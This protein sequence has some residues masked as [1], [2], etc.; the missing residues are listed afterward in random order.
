MYVHQKNHRCTPCLIIAYDQGGNTYNPVAISLR[1]PRRHLVCLSSCSAHDSYFII[2]GRTADGSVGLF[3]QSFTTTKPPRATSP[4]PVHLSE[5]ET[6]SPTVQVQTPQEDVPWDLLDGLAASL[7]NPSKG[8]LIII[9]LVFHS[10][11]NAD[12]GDVQF[13]CL[14][15]N[16]PSVTG[17]PSLDQGPESSPSTPSSK[18][19]PAFFSSRAFLRKRVIYAHFDILT[20]RSEYFATMLSSSFSENA[21]STR[22]GDRKIHSVVLE[23]A[24]FVTIYWLLK[25]IYT[26]RVTFRDEVDPRLAIEGVG[27]GW[28]AKWLDTSEEGEWEWKKFTRSQPGQE[29]IASRIDA[30]NVGSTAGSGDVKEG[31]A[32]GITVRHT[33]VPDPNPHPT[34]GPPPASALSIYRIAHRYGLDRLAASATKHVMATI[35]PEHCFGLLFA[36]G[37]WDELHGLVQVN[38]SPPHFAMA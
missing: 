30:W 13:I 10:D 33:P 31:R 21:H 27:T 23:E 37:A 3:P 18:L 36:S 12:T 5:P 29:L 6:D 25:W 4:P 15:R 1:W 28:S 24:D 38:A 26:N 14:E 7:D 22:P 19:G 16:D 34:P 17:H 35:T 11:R 9:P 20:R 8:H 2:K 32:V